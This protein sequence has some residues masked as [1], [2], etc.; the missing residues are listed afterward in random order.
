MAETI[1]LCM[2]RHSADSNLE[3][4]GSFFN[5]VD[6]EYG[7]RHQIRVAT[8]S[9]VNSA[10]TC[11]F[12]LAWAAAL[13]GYEDGEVQYFAM[14]HGDVVPPKYWLGLMHADINAA[15]VDVL[16][17]VIPIKDD[18]G[19]T[20]TA[21]DDTGNHWRPRRIMLKELDTLP[22]IFEDVHVGGPLLLN[23]G[24]WICKLGP[25]CLGDGD[26]LP[27]LYFTVYNEIYKPKVGRRITNFI[28]EDWDFSRQARLRG[29]RLA[30]SQ[31]LTVGHF[32]GVLWHSGMRHGWDHDKQN[33][34]REEHR[35]GDG[36]AA[37]RDPAC[38]LL[39]R[40]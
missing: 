27:D 8:H 16:S 21:V 13:D 17:S 6:P 23:T 40:P 19:K 18:S 29:A 22:P 38:A 7:E 15:G 39:A 14:Q 28:P 20:S 30:A 5:C 24:L 11:N 37:H 33:A 34:P 35:N 9:G 3:G 36:K 10:L 25:W 4:A 26:K 32:G 31:K 12:N 2:P 1:V